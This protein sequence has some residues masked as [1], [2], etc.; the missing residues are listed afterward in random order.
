MLD[1]GIRVYL[2]MTHGSTELVAQISTFRMKLEQTNGR[3]LPHGDVEL[4]CTKV[5]ES[6][7][8]S[9]HADL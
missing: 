4:E 9:A 1:V 2:A 8:F 7:Y 5:S 3:Q 6:R